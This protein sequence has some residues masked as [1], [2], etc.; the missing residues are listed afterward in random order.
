MPTLSGVR[1]D[2]RQAAAYRWLAHRAGRSGF[3]RDPRRDAREKRRIVV[4]QSRTMLDERHVHGRA[5]VPPIRALAPVRNDA[6][7]DRRRQP[8]VSTSACHPRRRVVV[9]VIR[10]R[11]RQGKARVDRFACAREDPPAS[12][13]VLVMSPDYPPA[14]GGIQVLAHRLVR[15]AARV[16]PRV[17]TLDDRD[18]RAFD[19]SEPID[20]R[21]VRL[22]RHAR[23]ASIALLNARAVQEAHR[24]RPH[25]ILS[26]HIVTAPAA[27]VIRRGRHT[28]VVSTFTG[29]SSGEAAARRIRRPGGGLHRRGQRPLAAMALAAGLDPSRLRRIPP[30]VD[31]R[32][33]PSGYRSERPT[34]IT[35]ARLEDRY[36]GHDVLISAMSA[37]LERVPDAQWLVVG[38]GSLRPRAGGARQAGRAWKAASAS[39]AP[40]RTSN[41]TSCSTK[42]TSSS[43]RADFP[44]ARSGARFRDRVHGGRGARPAGRGRKCGRSSRCRRARSNRAAR[45]ADRSGCRGRGCLGLLLDRHRADAFGRAGAARAQAFAWERIARRVEDLLLELARGPG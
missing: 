12:P 4:S 3:H 40:S 1:G 36:K 21:R 43:C 32:E 18:A 30:G 10:L 24:F 6:D 15:H 34:L 8:P 37:I 44:A 9:R 7:S 27:Q 5:R 38:D 23:R 13:R 22:R 26:A 45:G 33:L 20:V 28:P 2:R 29:T 31:I 41:V 19:E 11:T 16:L 39:W 35:V 25:V 17:V 14:H 42:P